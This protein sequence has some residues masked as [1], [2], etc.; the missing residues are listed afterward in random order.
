ENLQVPVPPL[1][2]QQKI[3]A[4]LSSVDDVIEKTRAQIDKLKD[5][6]TGMMQ[7]LLTKG[8]GHTAFKDSPVGRIPEGWEVVGLESLLAKVDYPMRSGPFGSSLLKSELV[9]KGIPYLGIDNVHVERFENKF[10][11]FVSE[12]KFEELKRYAVREKDVMVTIMGTV[13][14]CCVVPDGVGRAL[15]SKHVWTMTFDQELCIPEL[16]CWQ[17]NYANWVHEQ[18]KNE[19]QGGVMDSI[20]SKTLKGLLLPLPPICEQQKIAEAHARISRVILGKAE[21]LSATTNLKKSLMQDLLTGKLRVN[22]DNKE[23]AVA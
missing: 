13:G 9:Q 10:R 11:R 7:E 5:L 22:V 12:E 19:S 1:P 4:I 6:K 3:A 15:S 2:E 20:S 16:I 17:I 21:K 14:R 18:F 8:I 23:N